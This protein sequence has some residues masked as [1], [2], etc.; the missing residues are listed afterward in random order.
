MGV[1]WFTI[2]LCVGAPYGT[3]PSTKLSSGPKITSG[4][5]AVRRRNTAAAGPR[6]RPVRPTGEAH[7]GS[8]RR[9]SEA[10]SR[11]PLAAPELTAPHL[12]LSRQRRRHQQQNDERNLRDSHGYCQAR[13]PPPQ[14]HLQAI[15]NSS[16]TV[17]RSLKSLNPN[18]CC[19]A[20]GVSGLQWRDLS[21]GTGRHP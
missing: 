3:G 8:G 2:S 14:E 5:P 11:R 19:S 16:R 1:F 20:F 17:L 6:F 18:P 13:K 4:E 12:F 10:D 7:A 9:R 15:P 21:A